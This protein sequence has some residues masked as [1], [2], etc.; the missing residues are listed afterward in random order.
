M[1]V[2]YHP[3]KAALLPKIAQLEHAVDHVVFVD[4]TETGF[5]WQVTFFQQRCPQR[6]STETYL[7]LSANY[8]IAKAQNL[9]LEYI[10]Q[11]FSDTDTVVFFDQ[12]S[13]IEPSLPRQLAQAFDRLAQLNQGPVAAV[14]PSFIDE[15]KGFVYPQ[16]NWSKQGIFQ[17]FIPDDTHTQQ[18]VCALISSGMTTK[19]ATLKT[20]GLFD[21]AL[22]IDYVDTDWCLRAQAKGYALYVIPTLTMHHAI[23]TDS[24]KVWGR[25]LSV[26]SPKRRY[27]MIRNSLYL[28]K[29]SYVSKRLGLSFVY[30]TLIH[31][32]ILIGLTPQKAAQTKAL[33]KGI[34]H[35]LATLRHPEEH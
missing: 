21:E 15:R 35:G 20:L 30:R 5:A 18:K 14:G 23:G 9:A 4:N 6:A 22:F 26:H 12:D 32:L 16:V 11:H 1:V 7:N 27:Y 29:K 19:V 31:H 10:F 3:I 13:S 2:L 17:R 34:A 28:L 8:G 33:F 25:N 24:V